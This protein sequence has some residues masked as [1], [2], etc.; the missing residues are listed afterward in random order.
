MPTARRGHAKWEKMNYRKSCKRYNDPGHAHVLTFS[1][2]RRQPILSKD[3][4]RAWLTDAIERARSKHEFHIW[5][6]VIMPEHMHLMLWPTA[7]NYNISEILNSI[8]QSVSKRA[9]VFVRRET[10]GFLKRM[11]DRQPNGSVHYRFWQRGGGYDRNIVA[12]ESTHIQIEY[13]HNNP[14]RRGLCIDPEDWPWSSAGNY[15]GLRMG[16][17]RIDRETVPALSVAGR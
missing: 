11:E 16:P 7:A 4:S 2:F 14:V 3:R 13:I 5:A 6:Y 12:P 1:C 15:A 9:L 8:K 17:L 10:P